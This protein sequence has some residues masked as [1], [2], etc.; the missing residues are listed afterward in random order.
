MSEFLIGELRQVIKELAYEY[1]EERG[2]PTGSPEVDWYKA[3]QRMK[4]STLASP[5][6]PPLS[7]FSMGPSE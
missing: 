4:S 6:G 2:R 5:V 1:W 7:A 3:E